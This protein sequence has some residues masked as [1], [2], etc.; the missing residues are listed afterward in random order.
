LSVLPGKPLVNSVNGEEA[1]LNHILPEVKEDGAAV[2]GLTMDENGIPDTA[3]WRLKVAE[4]IL[5]RAS[6]L[7]IPAEDVIIDPLVQTIG[8]NSKAAR[9]TLNMIGLVRSEFG[10]NINLGASKVS[11]GMPERHTINQAFQ[12]LGIGAGVTCAITD[13]MKLTLTIC[14]ADLLLGW[15]D[16]GRRL[17]GSWRTLEAA[18]VTQ[19]GA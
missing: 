17:L 14:A 10:V 7:G 16:R 18:Q 12:V 11:F 13:P 4:K 15:D 9:I 5:D 19:T 8:A 1:S 6:Q 3:E 2:I